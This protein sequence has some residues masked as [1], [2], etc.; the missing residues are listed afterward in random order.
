[1]FVQLGRGRTSQLLQH[2]LQFSAQNVDGVFGARLSKRPNAVGESPTGKHR[3][4]PA[5]NELGDV[6][7]RCDATIGHH[8][9]AISNGGRD[10][11]DRMDRGF[12]GIQLSTAVIGND[13]PIRAGRNGTLG[14]FNVKDS[15]DDQVAL[16]GI[17]NLST[18]W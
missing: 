17:A 10:R 13:Q 15:F 9:G 16:P 18:A 1:M 3:L 7:P 12:R 11:R 4:R 8:D 5:C 14:I 6:R 2:L